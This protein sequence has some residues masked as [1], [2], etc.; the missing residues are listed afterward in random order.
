MTMHHVLTLV[1]VAHC[2]GALKVPVIRC[3]A[4]F[5]GALLHVARSTEVV[6]LVVGHR[7]EARSR[8]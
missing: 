1:E 2:A 4:H 7:H 5:P 8:H 6:V 3:H